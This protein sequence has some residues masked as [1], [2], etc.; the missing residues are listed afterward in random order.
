MLNKFLLKK[1]KIENKY[2]KVNLILKF[3]NYKLVIYILNLIQT[4]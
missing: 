3:L 2:R 4:I 1:K